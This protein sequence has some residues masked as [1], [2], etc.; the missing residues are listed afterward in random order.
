MNSYILVTGASSG[1]GEGAVVELSKENRIILSGR[2]GEKL[3]QVRMKCAE[4]E[5]H[6]IWVC[7]LDK[8]RLDIFSSLTS[9]LIQHE[10]TI[11]AFVHCAGM[12]RI[13]P[14]R[15]FIPQYVDQIFNINIFS[16]IEII[17]VLLKKDNKKSLTNII[18]ISGLWSVRGDIGNSIYASSKGALNSLVYSLA[19]ELAPKVRVNAVSPGAILTPMTDTLLEDVSFRMKIEQDYPLG[20]GSVEDIVN[21]I[22]FLLSEQSKWATGQNYIVDGGRSTK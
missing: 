7:D 18:F 3:E 2:A 17:R 9:F 12:T 10:V 8:E 1:I 22:V 14:A 16:A 19:R 6:L 5:K 13:L 20:I 4:P 11:K 15:N 21:F